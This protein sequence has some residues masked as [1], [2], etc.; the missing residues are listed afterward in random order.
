MPARG[1]WRPRK[2]LAGIRNVQVLEGDMHA[3]GSPA[4]RYDLVLMMH[5]LPYSEKPAVAVAEAAR[6]LRK[7]GRPLACTLARHAHRGAVEAFD[8]R[9]LGFTVPELSRWRPA[10]GWRC[11]AA[12]W[13]RAS[14]GRRTSKC[15]RLSS[16]NNSEF[17]M[18][19][20][21]KISSRSSFFSV[22]IIHFDSKFTLEP[23]DIKVTIAFQVIHSGVK[24]SSS[25]FSDLDKSRYYR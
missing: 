3:T 20:L 19:L 14:S 2:R 22:I 9:N 4:A 24:V 11:S 12:C 25:R 15:S 13:P 6:L 5:A 10:P 18:R 7:G 17:G 21:L 8:H 23:C 16:A 1:W